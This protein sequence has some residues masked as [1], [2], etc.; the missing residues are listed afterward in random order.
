LRGARYHWSRIRWSPSARGPKRCEASRTSWGRQ[1]TA[2]RRQR[3][4]AW[5]HNNATVVALRIVELENKKGPVTRA[6]LDAVVN[7]FARARARYVPAEKLDE[8]D[9]FKGF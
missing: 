1:R 2:R 6:E 7:T 3:G 4:K 9:R 5:G 8:T